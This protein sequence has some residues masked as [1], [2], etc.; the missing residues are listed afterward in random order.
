M[1]DTSPLD[2]AQTQKAFEFIERIASGTCHGENGTDHG[3][4][5]RASQD[6]LEK[7]MQVQW[8]SRMWTV[9]ELILPTEGVFMF[10]EKH[11]SMDTMLKA[12][13]FSRMHHFQYCCPYKDLLVPRF[14]T[15]WSQR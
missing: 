1:V 4:S 10:G 8:W 5:L 13:A 15:N 2:P 3:E 7:L 11:V 6:A 12:C 9:Q 14:W